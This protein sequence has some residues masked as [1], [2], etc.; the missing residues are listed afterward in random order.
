MSKSASTVGCVCVEILIFQ[1]KS[2]G[3]QGS[4]CATARLMWYFLFEFPVKTTSS[5][6]K[7]AIQLGIGYTVG[8]LTSKPDRDV[9][10]Q[11][12]YV[13]ESVF[14]PRSVIPHAHPQCYIH[15]NTFSAY[16]FLCAEGLCVVIRLRPC[17]VSSRL[18]VCRTW[19]IGELL[20]KNRLCVGW[21][22]MNGKRV[23]GT[24]RLDGLRK[25][26]MSG[27]RIKNMNSCY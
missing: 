3:K 4:K 13:V 20:R 10:M 21:L 9:L 23:K 19:W 11:D 15:R 25:Y 8:N 7:G 17:R 2:K 6:L 1:I 26:C 18:F 22:W 16:V 5:A 14:L 12:F 27:S 24:L